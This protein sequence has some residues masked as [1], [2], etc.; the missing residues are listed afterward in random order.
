MR[1]Q[2]S[3]ALRASVKDASHFNVSHIA[4]QA[5]VLH[6]SGRASFGLQ[7]GATV[8]VFDGVRKRLHILESL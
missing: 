3:A 5:I 1:L 6:L 2:I 8:S 7:A 4:N